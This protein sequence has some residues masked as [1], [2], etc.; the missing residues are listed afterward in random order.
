[1][2]SILLIPSVISVSILRSLCR[3]SPF[4]ASSLGFLGSGQDNNSLTLSRE[5][6]V[7]GRGSIRGGGDITV[8][9]QVTAPPGTVCEAGAPSFIMG[10]HGACV[11]FLP[12]ELVFFYSLCPRFWS[13][14]DLVLLRG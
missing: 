8:L 10:F 1:M 4:F 5:G 14:W 7:G 11:S 3:V 12:W 2:G 9:L 6:E 13:H